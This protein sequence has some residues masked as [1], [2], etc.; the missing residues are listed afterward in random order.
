MTQDKI[1][2]AMQE[3]YSKTFSA[4]GCSSE[5]VDWGNKQQAVALRHRAMEAVIRSY[6]ASIL[7][8]GC[9]Y[10][11]FLDYAQE[12]E[13]LSYTGIDL[14]ED[15]VKSGR[16]LHPKAKFIC[17]D[18]L[19]SQISPRSYDYVI[20]NG[21]LTQKLVATT[22]EMDE[23]ARQLVRKMF[24]TAKIGIAFNIMSTH[25][26]FQVENLYYK[27]PLEMLGWV[28]NEISPHVRL[29]HAY[30]LYE[31]TLYVYTSKEFAH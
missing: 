10:G 16:S 7:D 30:P 27:D 31:Y 13:N 4:H 28:M 6:P 9:G 29:D 22:A 3:H 25:V 19:N 11:A 1:S 2:K 18:F 14:V 23:Y 21:I 12:P 24:E 5:G 8:V 17:G 20:C 15:M 26:N